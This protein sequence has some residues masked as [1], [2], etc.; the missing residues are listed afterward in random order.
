M[1]LD[2]FLQKT[3]RLEVARY[4]KPKDR[5]AIARS[6]VAF[7]GSLQKHPVDP[8]K[9]ILIPDPHSTKITY[10]EFNREDI[11]YL[12]KLSGVTNMNGETA[13]ITRIW[14]KKNRIAVRCTP[15][16]VNNAES[17]P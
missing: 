13:N 3:E 8:Q 16:V 10:F 9:I 5:L 7:I 4:K 1:T 12:E 6:H 11:R 14:V 2:I 15:F 17:I